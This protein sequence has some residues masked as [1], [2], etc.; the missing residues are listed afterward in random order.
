MGR[1]LL[2]SYAIVQAGQWARMRFYGSSLWR[3]R[4]SKGFPFCR[5]K[6]VPFTV[7]RLKAA[8][9]HGPL[10]AS[11]LFDRLRAASRDARDP[12]GARGSWTAHDR[13]EHQH[14]RAIKAFRQVLYIDPGFSRANEIHLRL[15]LMFKVIADYESSLK[16]L[17][18]RTL[19]LFLF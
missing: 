16:V 10:S 6:K 8:F 17:I 14:A 2:G 7:T 3:G 9:C 11:C 19:S 4:A 15:G 5:G 13:Y 12:G 18:P 1:R